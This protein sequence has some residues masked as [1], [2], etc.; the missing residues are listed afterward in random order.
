MR[1]S[2]IFTMAAALAVPAMAEPPGRGPG[3]SSSVV[4]SSVTN[5]QTNVSAA[6]KDNSAV[7]TGVAVQGAT[8]RNSTID[9]KVTGDFKATGNSDVSVGVNVG[10]NVANSTL[11]SETKANVD[12]SGNSKFTG[13]Q[14][15]DGARNANIKTQLDARKVELNN[16][17]LNAG[18]VSGSVDRKDIS[19][20]VTLDPINSRGGTTNI[21][22]VKVNDG[23]ASGGATRQKSTGSLSGVAPGSGA[24]NIG[25]VEVGSPTVREVEVTV[26][27]G[28]GKFGKSVK[29]RHIGSMYDGKVAPDGTLIEYV[30]KEEKEKALSDGKSVGNVKADGTN[31]RKVKVIVE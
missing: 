3:T 15:I 17:T 22:T 18:T 6:A 19:T 8:V 16:A 10:G 4:N 5:I 23:S 14:D 12:A 11:K 1:A 9:N 25:T 30:S 28:N 21:G 20:N 29:D 24:T 27:E 13:G 31:A 26:G 2:A 7:N